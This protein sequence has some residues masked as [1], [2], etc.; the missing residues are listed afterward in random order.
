MIKDNQKRLNRVHVVLDAVV[1]ILAYALAW[2][3]VL[4]GKVIP[5]EANMG[6]LEPRVYFVAPIFIVPVYLIL[7]GAFHLYV[8]KRIQGRRSEFAN[9]CKANTIGLMIFTFVLFGGRSFIPH[10]NYFSARMLLGFFACNIVLL[11]AERMGIRVFLRSLRTN[12]YNQKHVLLIGYSRAAEGF[13][14]RVISNP[15]W[16]YHIQGILD[17]HQPLG[18]SY[19]GIRVLGPISSLGSFLDANTLDEIAITLS[20]KEYENLEQIVAS[21]E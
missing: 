2:F 8:P 21:C 13:I 12:G 17:N 1:T 7:Y 18:Y 20:L 16:G 5:L 19:K 6:V 11:E 4:S 3:I 15:E 9:I 14:D 10:M